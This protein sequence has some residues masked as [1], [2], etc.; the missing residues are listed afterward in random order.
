MNTKI[1][2]LTYSLFQLQKIIIYT[3]SITDYFSGVVSFGYGCAR[4]NALGVYTNV[5]RHMDWIL[6]TI[7]PQQNGPGKNPPNKNPPN[8]KPNSKPQRRPAQS[9]SPILNLWDVGDFAFKKRN[10][11][12]RKRL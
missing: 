7:D 10:R 5:A 3:Y 4:P 8:K 9:H 2:N 11:R 12:Y 6:N 1:N